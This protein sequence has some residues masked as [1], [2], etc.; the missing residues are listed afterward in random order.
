MKI[1]NANIFC[2]DGIFKM[3]CLT[4]ENDTIKKIEYC[5]YKDSQH[6]L[7]KDV[8]DA[9]GM[10]V[11]PGLVDIHLHGAN[12]YD[13]CD[14]NE[15]AMEE[16]IRY[17]LQHGITSL[18]PATMTLPETRLKEICKIASRFKD[19]SQICGITMEGPFISKEKKGAQNE[20]YVRKPEVAFFKRLSTMKPGLIKQITI[21]PEV[22]GAYDFVSEVS[23]DVV[24]SLAH[25]TADYEI[26][27]I[28]FEYGANHVTHLYNAMKPFSHKEPGVI[29]AAFD[30]KNVFVELICDGIHVNESVVRAT[31]QLFGATRI[32]MI[33]D[34][35]RA[36]GMPDGV[37]ELGGQNVYVEG[38]KAILEDGTLAG[39]V[40]NLYDC[41]R[42]A[43]TKMQIPLE[44][45]V[46]SCTQTPA[47]SL[48]LEKECGILEEG[49]K[50][51]FLIMDKELNLKYVFKNGTQQE[52]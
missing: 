31:F 26:A 6:E 16:M 38:K 21:A 14:A 49:R 39:S 25:T 10:Y 18:V 36:T 24:V 43:A 52:L 51:D 13:I 4:Y 41:M 44:D 33:S 40:S 28:A 2:K 5:P 35:M 47:Y 23:K 7:K 27:K 48:G 30:N 11:I 42:T 17:Q 20:D 22:E 45:V 19:K 34:S 1:I 3:G 9:K 29:G 32:C 8:L 50:A 15:K 37:Y 46:L 12:G